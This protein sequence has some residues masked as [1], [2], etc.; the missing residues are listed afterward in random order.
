MATRQAN[1]PARILAHGSRS[2][3]ATR[4]ASGGLHL[5]TS[6]AIV[7]PRPSWPSATIR[8]ASLGRAMPDGELRRGIDGGETFRRVLGIDPDQRCHPTAAKKWFMAS[9]R[10]SKIEVAAIATIVLSVVVPA[11]VLLSP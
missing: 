2:D 10:L 9:R 6:A 8:L 1:A 3:R 11:V 7:G 5:R 4:H